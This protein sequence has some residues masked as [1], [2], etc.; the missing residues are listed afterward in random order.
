MRR[1]NEKGTEEI[2]NATRREVPSRFTAVFLRPCRGK[3]RTGGLMAGFGRR[4]CISSNEKGTEEICNAEN[5]PK[6]GVRPLPVWKKHRHGASPAFSRPNTRQPMSGAF[7]H[8]AGG[9]KPFHGRFS[10]SMPGKGADWRADG[11]L[12]MAGFAS[13]APLPCYRD[14]HEKCEIV[15]GCGARAVTVAFEED[16]CHVS[17]SLF[18]AGWVAGLGARR[19]QRG[20]FQHRLFKSSAP[21]GF[22]AH[23]RFRPRLSNEELVW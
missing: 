13:P 19:G 9:L 14:S 6:T 11:G 15:L 7:F 22:P 1:G 4:I 17:S 10:A 8:A 16:I 21:G 23:L 20:V 3:A 18:I 5:R 2:C 12:W